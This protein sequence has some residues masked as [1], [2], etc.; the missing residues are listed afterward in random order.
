MS[1]QEKFTAALRKLADGRGLGPRRSSR[2]AVT[3][4]ARSARAVAAMSKKPNAA[5]AA[6]AAELE[7]SGDRVYAYDYRGRSVIDAFRRYLETD[8]AE[9]ITKPLYGFLTSVCGFIAHYDLEGFR[10]TYPNAHLLLKFMAADRGLMGML[11]CGQRLPERVYRDGMIDAEVCEELATLV[12]RHGERAERSYAE[13]V[14]AQA[15]AKAIECA[16]L[17][18][19]VLVPQ[20]FTLL[21]A[22]SAGSA[23]EEESPPAGLQELAERRGLRLV[24]E[25]RLL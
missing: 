25:G 1:M 15:A 22:D 8:D 19:W 17:L 23:G 3:A 9:K 18:R 12:E 21:P 11:R 2:R 6:R 13:A 24:P 10:H 5:Q 14:A 4:P 16:G 7:E 20:G